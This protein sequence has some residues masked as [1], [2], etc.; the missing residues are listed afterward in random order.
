MSLV[1]GKS[2]QNG[3]RVFEA[4]ARHLSFTAAAVELRSTQSAVS[5]QVRALEDALELRLFD[6]IHRGVRLTEAGQALF[7][8]VQEGFSIIEQTIDRLQQRQQNP[9]LNILT[10]FSLAAYWLMPRLP[11][12]R[13]DHPHIDVRILTS[14][15]ILGWR[16][17]EVDVVI[18]FCD[19]RGME[20]ALPLFHEEVFPVCSAG[21]LE[22]HGPIQQLSSLADLPLLTLTA[23]QQ[24][25]LDWPNYFQQ[26]GGMP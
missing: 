6:R 13:R 8:S 16:G 14:Q 5:Q 19:A 7:V 2:L 18:K 11:M 12:F 3:L 15:E 4:A 1:A 20:E 21:F 24:H 26:L 25:W 17:Q 10:D 23:G 9:H 22:Q